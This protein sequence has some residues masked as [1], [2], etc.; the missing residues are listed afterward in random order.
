[1]RRPGVIM[2]ITILL[3][4]TTAPPVSAETCLAPVRPFVPRDPADARDF[5][6]II[7]SDFEIYIEDM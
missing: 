6:D 5:A 7:R 1:M 3:L 4:G 2:P